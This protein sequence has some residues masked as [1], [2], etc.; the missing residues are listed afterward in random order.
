MAHVALLPDGGLL[1]YR[2]AGEGADVVMLHGISSHAASWHKQFDD[3]GLCADCRLWAWDAPGYGASTALAGEGPR[4]ADYAAVL[5]QWLDVLR[6]ERVVLLGHSL[7]AMMAAAFAA[8]YPGRVAGLILADPAQGY[9]ATDAARRELIFNIRRE[10]AEDFSGYAA[11][12]AER[13]LRPGADGM[14]VDTVRAGMAALRR[15]G[16]L[17]AAHMLTEDALAPCLCDYRGP[18]EIWCGDQD[19]ITPPQDA[20]ALAQQTGAPLRMLL[21][22]GHACYLDAPA[23]FNRLLRDVA[24]R[25][26]GEAS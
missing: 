20:A 23:Q 18:L 24:Q 7:G 26:A 4:A 25:F 3:S 14:N 19:G 22:A 15:D 2:R 21:D 10:Q 13:L 6:L 9:G 8:R 16:F 5:A 11:R 1:S 12:R 17:A